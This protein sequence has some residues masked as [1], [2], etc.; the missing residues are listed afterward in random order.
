MIV[1]YPVVL[2][3]AGY[4]MWKSRQRG[5]GARGWIWFNAWVVAGALFLFSLLTGLSVGLLLF[6]AAALAVLWLAV[7]AP[8]W[9]EAAGFPVGAALVGIGLLLFV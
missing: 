5:M 2:A 3:G 6:P 8:Y 1:L 9:R 4:L 7:H